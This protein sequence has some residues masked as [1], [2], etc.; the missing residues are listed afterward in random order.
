MGSLCKRFPNAFWRRSVSNL[1]CFQTCVQ[2]CFQKFFKSV[3][4]LSTC[5]LNRQEWKQGV[6]GIGKCLLKY[7]K[8]AVDDMPVEAT[9]PE[10]LLCEIQDSKIQIPASIRQQYLNDPIRAVDWRATLKEF[11]RKWA[12]DVTPTDQQAG[13]QAQS[14]EATFSWQTVYPDEPCTK[15]EME[16]K[17]G[18]SATSFAIT[19]TLAG[20]IVEGPRLFVV[21]TGDGEFGTEQPVICFGAGVWLLENKAEAFLQDWEFVFKYPLAKI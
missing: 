8:E 11:D 20:H 6:G 13:R 15:S 21:S 19:E 18:T 7:Q 14:D 10:L 9:P 4:F 17:Y 12:E 3:C 2:A 16:A 1:R 5:F